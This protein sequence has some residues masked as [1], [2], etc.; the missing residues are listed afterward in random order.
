MDDKREGHPESIDNAYHAAGWSCHPVTDSRGESLA[1]AGGDSWANDTVP[2]K[3]VL[4]SAKVKCINFPSP[5]PSHP[6]LGH[7][8]S[9]V[10]HHR[11]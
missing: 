11:K 6:V 7:A 1:F 10:S 8:H 3:E 2:S 5:S 9:Q 4:H